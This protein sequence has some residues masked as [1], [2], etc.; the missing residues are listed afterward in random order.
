[1]V[2]FCA[3][4][5]CLGSWPQL[6]HCPQ[7]VCTWR[8]GPWIRSQRRLGIVVAA[9]TVGEAV[10]E[11]L[12]SRQAT[13]VSSFVDSLL[14]WNQRMNLTAV[15]E[16]EEVMERHIMDSL[17]LLPVLE[18]AYGEHT[19]KRSVEQLEVIDVGTGAGLPGIVFAIARPAWK[20]TLLESLQKRCNFLDYAVERSGLSNVKVVRARA[21]DGG[22]D[23]THREAYDVAVARAVAEMRVLSELCLPFVRV[24]GIF[25][26]AKGPGPEEEVESAKKAIG[27]LGASLISISTVDSRGPLG[28]RTAVVCQKRKST[29]AKYPRRPGTPSKTPL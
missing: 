23:K 1:M 12:D 29:P 5:R 17:A 16:R 24:G 26:A 28:Q 8:R 4:M 15:T 27:L 25:V 21:E 7:K 3:P 14:D 10:C 6:V 20:I 9:G 18:T 11:V 19:S 22:Q 13:Q 2:L